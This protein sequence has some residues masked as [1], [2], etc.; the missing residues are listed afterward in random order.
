MKKWTAIVTAMAAV[1]LL[2]YGFTF[3]GGNRASATS[4]SAAGT[5]ASIDTAKHQIVLT[6]SDGNHT[7][8]LSKTVWI[9]RNEQKAA[10]ADVKTGDQAKL[11]FNS[12]QQA[13]YVMVSSADFAAASPPSEAPAPSSPAGQTPSAAPSATPEPMPSAVPPAPQPPTAS[14]AA[15]A[16]SITD[17]LE[18]LEISLSG[19]NHKVKLKQEG[20]DG[21]TK[22]EVEIEQK[23]DGDIHLKGV[24]AEQFI[25]QLLAAVHYR[26]DM[27]KNELA[28]AIA[29]TLNLEFTK[30][31]VKM[32]IK[33]GY[34][35]NE[36]HGY[37]KNKDNGNGKD[38]GN[39]KGKDKAMNKDKDKDKSKD[40]DKGKDKDKE[41]ANNDNDR[42]D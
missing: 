23:D 25:R 26:T 37:D 16:D 39:D 5:I 3:F 32:E 17:A 31:D 13:A 24:Q 2:V 41:R 19:P 20:N 7:Y 21:K 1:S 35:K 34:L 6:E 22:A 9:Y 29:K 33:H 11:V 30:S 10:L 42:D 4:A 27:D 18:K 8:P 15:S 14:P 28:L 40:K 36:S 38:N 12:R